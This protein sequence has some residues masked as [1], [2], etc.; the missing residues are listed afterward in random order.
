VRVLIVGA[1]PSAAFAALACKD[2]GITPIVMTKDVPI[3][4]PGAFYIHR[5]PF[6]RH[7]NIR[8]RRI[9]CYLHG[10]NRAHYAQRI[11]GADV[12]TSCPDVVKETFGYNPYEL[13]PTLWEGIAPQA[14]ITLTP[15]QVRHLSASFDA[16]ICSIPLTP[17]PTTPIKMYV[18]GPIAATKA[19]NYTT[20]EH[21]LAGMLNVPEEGIQPQSILY[22]ASP[23]GAWAR[24]SWLW[25]HIWVESVEPIKFL[26]S[27]HIIYKLPR[28]TTPQ[29]VSEDPRILLIGRWGTWK[30]NYLCHQAYWD[31]Y[32]KLKPGI[33]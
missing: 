14:G 6:G 3:E 23:H 9:T 31:T 28:Q 11:Y 17:P 27:C 30:I 15:G 13:L 4:F 32:M 7:F 10:Y 19:F 20:G 29:E 1:G 22:N 16:V 5:V 26:P 33:T 18:H 12:P 2:L 25:D 8:S 24:I 21:W